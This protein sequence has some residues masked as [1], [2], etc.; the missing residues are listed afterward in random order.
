[1]YIPLTFPKHPSI[2]GVIVHVWC[3]FSGKL[4]YTQHQ[5]KNDKLMGPGL[6]VRR[7]RGKTQNGAVIL[8]TLIDVSKELFEGEYES[9]SVKT[10]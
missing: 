9:F 6:A 1:M 4:S 5:T 7:I 2:N 10:E 3:V 8:T